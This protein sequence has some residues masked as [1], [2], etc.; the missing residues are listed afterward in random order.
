MHSNRVSHS[1]YSV[2][3]FV[4]SEDIV[5]SE[6]CLSS[7]ISGCYRFTHILSVVRPIGS[8]LQEHKLS[9]CSTNFHALTR[10]CFIHL[11]NIS[12]FSN[13]RSTDLHVIIISLSL[14]NV[15]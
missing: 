4:Y 3:E 8:V 10:M 1:L 6:D 14:K 9:C 15:K 2:A 12:D 5:Q 7:F 13:I 11:L